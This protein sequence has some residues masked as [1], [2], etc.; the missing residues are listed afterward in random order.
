MEAGML[1]TTLTVLVT[2]TVCFAIA[3]TA[4]FGAHSRRVIQMKVG[5]VVV[6]KTGN[7]QCQALNKT[8]VACGQNKLAGA[9]HVYFT[10]HQLNVVRFNN[11]GTKYTVLWSVKR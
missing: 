4:G 10:P 11:A 3:A 6:L 9:T 8:T 2:A 5:D 7:I 1:K